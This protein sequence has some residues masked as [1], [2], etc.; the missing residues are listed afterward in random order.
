MTKRRIDLAW[1]KSTLLALSALLAIACGPTEEPEPAAAPPAVADDPHSF[2]RSEEV[3][4]SHLAL[5]LAVDFEAQK[6][7]GRASRR[8]PS[9][10]RR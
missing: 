3:R 5:D 2:A 8:R 1:T 6:L 10:T 9:T 7:S 4:V